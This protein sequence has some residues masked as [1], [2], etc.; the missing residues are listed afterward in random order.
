[1]ILTR[2]VL[3]SG[4]MVGFEL[5]FMEEDAPYVFSLVLD[6]LIFRLIIQDRKSTRLNSSHT[7]ISRMP[8]SA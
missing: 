3:I 7:D 6:L 2:L 4:V 8:S 5:K 1:M